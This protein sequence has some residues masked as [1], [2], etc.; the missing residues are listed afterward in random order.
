VRQRAWG[1]LRWTVGVVVV[2]IVATTAIFFGISPRSDFLV[3]TWFQQAAPLPD[4]P[5]AL[6]VLLGNAEVMILGSGIVGGL[7]FLQNPLVGRR[8]LWLA[9]GIGVVSLIAVAL[10][11]LIAH[12]GP[13]PSLQRHVF[14]V[15]LS[16]QLPG[17]FPSGHTMRTTFLAALTLRARPLLAGLLVVTMMVG[18]VYL[19]DHWLSDVLGGMILGWTSAGLMKVARPNSGA[20][21]SGSSSRASKIAP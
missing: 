14:E 10:K 1:S 19:G 16:L 13:P 12:P 9:V 15:G 5:A 11:F 20:S 2:A 6:L 4:V 18:L 21:P 17:S 7:L 3:T 8:I